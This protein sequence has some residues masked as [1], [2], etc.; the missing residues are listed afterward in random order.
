MKNLKDDIS[1]IMDN[2]KYLSETNIITV[3]DE[4][5]CK[6]NELFKHHGLDDLLFELIVD[7]QSVSI[8]PTRII[9]KYALF[10]IECE[11]DENSPSITQYFIFEK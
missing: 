2:K 4:I 7:E 11:D 8:V 10:G 6:L 9:D 5:V 3:H 1:D